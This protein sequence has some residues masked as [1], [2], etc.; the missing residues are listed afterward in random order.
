[1][2]FAEGKKKSP[3]EAKNENEKEFSLLLH[4]H[5]YIHDATDAT[6][7]WDRSDS[8]KSVP[9]WC[10]CTCSIIAE[11]MINK[12]WPLT[13]AF[14]AAWFVSLKF[15]SFACDISIIFNAGIRKTC[16]ITELRTHYVPFWNTDN[17]SPEVMSTTG[18]LS[19]LGK[20]DVV[21]HRYNLGWLGNREIGQISLFQVPDELLRLWKGNRLTVK[22]K[23]GLGVC[24]P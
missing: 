17:R 14:G 6:S 10:F 13:C 23:T 12:K 24:A 1:M 3:V 8:V 5:A 7:W 22:K 21:R 16:I 19:S 20:H 18:F 4:M 15:W 2:A 11:P 9:S